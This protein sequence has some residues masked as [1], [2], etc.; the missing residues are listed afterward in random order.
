ML[1]TIDRWLHPLARIWRHCYEKDRDKIRAK[2]DCSTEIYTRMNGRGRI[3]HYSH[4]EAEVTISRHPATVVEQDDGRLNVQEVAHD[5]VKE[6]NV[7]QEAFLTYLKA[8]RGEWGR[9][10]KAYETE[11]II[12]AM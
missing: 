5:Q 6:V 7:E 3:Y 10:P 4:R 8:Y 12:E 1:S 2:S 9:H 11:W